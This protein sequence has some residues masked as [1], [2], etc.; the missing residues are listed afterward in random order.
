[1]MLLTG[2]FRFDRAASAALVLLFIA[3]VYLPLCAASD[4]LLVVDTVKHDVHPIGRNST[5]FS[6]VMRDDILIS[7]FTTS[8]SEIS[9]RK[10]VFE[11]VTETDIPVNSNGSFS[12][13]LQLDID[14]G[15]A[16]AAERGEIEV[17]VL[18]TRGQVTRE[19]DVA[20]GQKTGDTFS[21]GT[22]GAALNAGAQGYPHTFVAYN[23]PWLFYIGQ[24]VDD[25]GKSVQST[26][27]DV[28]SQ[29]AKFDA[30]SLHYTEDPS[31][32]ALIKQKNPNVK[33]FAY[34][35]PVLC[36]KS[37]DP[38]S[39]YQR[40]VKH[41]PE[42]FLY[43]SADTRQNQT[44]PLVAYNGTEQVMDLTTDWRAEILNLSKN[45]LAN[46]F[47]GLYIDCA[48]DDPSLCYGFGAT[49]APAG[50]WHT[51][52]NAYLDD[53]RVAGKMNFYNGQS[54]V[55]VP[56]NRDFFDRTDGWMDEGFISNNGWQL[57]AIDM[58]QY[59]SAADKFSVFYAM[60]SKGAARD[61]YF[62][63]A[64]LSDGYF[65][66]SPASTRWF[67]DYG[68]Y[69]GAALGQAYEV[70]GSP[71]IWARDYAEAKIIVNP[72]S[73]AVAV[74]VVGYLDSHGKP[75]SK[76]VIKPKQG[77][78]L[79]SNDRPT[80]VTLSADTTTPFVGQSVS[81][82][83]ALSWLD[84][85]TG[86]WAPI[87]SGKPVTIYHYYNGVR[88]DDVTN[89]NT[90]ANGQATATVSFASAGQRT[91]YATF[92]GDS[93]YGGSTSSV[94]TVNV[95]TLGATQLSLG[96]SATTPT[97]GQLV[98]FTA[99]LKS[100]STP[101]SGKPLT[102]YHYY[103]GVRYNDVT[104]QNTDAN[105]QATATVSFASA[106]QRTYYATFAGDSSHP[107]ATSGVVT[108]NVK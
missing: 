34:V 19:F 77:V 36:Y 10:K 18:A 57:S 102:I 60:N 90:D 7:G 40:V 106:G 101:L 55:V 8:D 3:S 37:A 4:P 54:P 39:E 85:S 100:G 82:T 44:N 76:I 29:L 31:N 45:A 61:F 30:V 93:A 64:L 98:T 24:F 70:Q 51:A 84:R 73:A 58:P 27:D 103:N 83:A 11:D 2:S 88:Y 46:G 108:T 53:V 32:I 41:H 79:V 86:A 28:A 25:T 72:T 52:L 87:T 9:V 80:K 38:N 56:T 66:Y 71:G 69:C 91:Y 1:M 21:N 6:E 104:N 105:G 92:A 81:F 33:V 50:D 95:G 22:I 20:L 43:P 75:T 99:T 89:Q 42:W 74:N 63:S 59:A 49:T 96:A 13:H 97:V 67:A 14:P 5:S 65:F 94:L 68:T 107:A 17:T 26:V 78:I 62:T 16:R 23:N 47:D 12:T 15:S 35:N 48:C